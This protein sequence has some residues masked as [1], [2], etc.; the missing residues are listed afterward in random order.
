MKCAWTALS[1]G[2]ADTM[3][4]PARIRIDLVLVPHAAQRRRLFAGAAAAVRLRPGCSCRLRT[5]AWEDPRAV[6]G[7]DGDAIIVHGRL[8]AGQVGAALARLGRPIIN[9]G[10]AGAVPGALDLGL[11]DHA[12]G[13]EAAGHL[14]AAGWRPIS[15]V[16]YAELRFSEQRIA[17]AGL[18]PGAPEPWRGRPRVPNQD[19]AEWLRHLPPGSGIVAVNDDAALLVAELAEALGR[20][21]GSDF[22]LVGCG[23]DEVL[24]HAAAVSLSSVIVPS[25]AIGAAAV[26]AALA[27]LAGG[28]PEPHLFAPLGVAARSSSEISAQADPLVGAALR[29]IRDGVGQALRISRLAS[30]LGVPMRT[31]QARFLAAI[32]HSPRDE[33]VRQRL[34]RAGLLLAT[35]DL[36]VAAVAKRCGLASP[37]RLHD[38]FQR[39][40]GNPGAWRRL[41]RG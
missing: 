14:R 17:G 28:R 9:I 5:E 23:D 41:H 8:Q 18:E 13:R 31:L 29:R 12:I 27:L 37:Q 35:T 10:D 21:P 26:Q 34:E 6:P 39:H 15:A 7:L 38:L 30:D 24:C 33:L 36:S 32:G 4:G 25:A 16:G 3:P 1:P 2:D 20:R 11:D 40:R 19:L 22:G